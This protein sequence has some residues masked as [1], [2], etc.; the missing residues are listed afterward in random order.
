MILLVLKTAFKIVLLEKVKYWGGG[1]AS[2]HLKRLLGLQLDLGII[3]SW[4]DT[5][6]QAISVLLL[7]I[8]NL[9]E[10]LPQLSYSETR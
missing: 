4:S 10:Y 2:R 9:A 3:T 1:E 6:S 7:D 8:T 5:H